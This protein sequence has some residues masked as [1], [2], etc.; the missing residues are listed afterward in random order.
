NLVVEASYIGDRGVWWSGIGQ[1]NLGLLNQVSPDT[2]AKF[3]LHPYTNA[4]DNLLLSSAI[5]TSG[6]TARVG[7]LLPYAGY[8]TNSTLNNTLKAY[9]QFGSVALGG[10]AVTGAPTG[11][12]YYD[13]LQAKATQRLSH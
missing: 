5:N 13:S 2:Y 11:S 7:N 1:Q 6:V 9:P 10:F 8:P 4:A 12:T 3:G